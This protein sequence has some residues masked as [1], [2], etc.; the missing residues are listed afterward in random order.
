MKTT[1]F[2]IITFIIMTT[3]IQAEVNVEQD[4]KAYNAILNNVTVFFQGAELTHTLT[5]NL[6]KGGNEI[7]IEGL[8]PVI[9]KNSLKIKATKGV[10]VSSSEFSTD[11]L[12]NSK[13]N[14]EVKKLQ[15]SIDLCSAQLSQLD[16]EI[17]IN[18]ELKVLLQKGIDKNISGSEK[19]LGL[20]DLMRNMEYYR[21]K[22]ADIEKIL[23]EKNKKKTEITQ[24]IQRLNDQLAQE[25]LKNNKTS[26]ILKLE[27][28]S[29]ALAP[30]EITISYYTPSAAWVPYYDINIEST[31]K[32]I[33]IAG[34]AKIRQ[35]TG[36]DWDKV[37]LTLSTAMP[38]NGK[39]APLFSTWF[40]ENVIPQRWGTKKLGRSN[41]IASQMAYSYADDMQAPRI[42]RDSNEKNYESEGNSVTQ[43]FLV[44]GEP[45]DADYVASLDQN[46]IKDTQQ[47]DNGMVN[48]ITKSSMDD[49]ITVSD[50]Q[51][52]VTYNI[53]MPYTI[54]GNG[55]EQSLDLQ[56]RQ[57][58]AEYKYYSAPK[59]DTET[60]LIADISDWQKLGLLTGKANITYDGTYIGE[61][62]IDANS[63]HKKLSL[64][65]GTDKRVAVK[66]EKM[67]DYSSTKFLGGDIKQV[68]TYNLTV[69]NNQNKPVN[70]VLKDQYPRSTQKNIEV[71]LLKET[72]SWTAN[73]EETGVIS[74]E[75]TLQP[76]ETK[77]YKISYSVKYPK[78]STL[79]L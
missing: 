6:K 37:K 75:E 66:R 16:T 20:D 8:S 61:T 51:I 40:L 45:V 47:L 72:T 44:N 23:A 39:I 3:T 41:M 28:T 7:K 42:V 12:S 33:N 15:D 48:I 4:Q 11:F 19:G 73:K 60:Y 38:S 58:V 10:L 67:Q 24:T 56:N 25:S 79:N 49:Y 22:S 69:K 76:G 55:K 63:T 64:T 34:K 2:G 68:F 53:E 70:M 30:S 57:A 78:G 1:L 46:M 32:P 14:P 59:L 43:Q 27:L 5:V 54:P 65:L 36:L 26:G 62:F 29:P 50:N 31:D 77:I 52:N 35:T 13:K 18:T 74:W 9:D 21:T 71:E 17:N